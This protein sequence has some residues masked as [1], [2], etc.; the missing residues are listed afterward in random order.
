MTDDTFNVSKYNEKKS[1]LDLYCEQHKGASEQRST[2]W[3]NLTYV[4]FGGSE[5]ATLSGDS[6]YEKISDLVAKKS[7]LT[8]LKGNLPMRWGTYLEKSVAKIVTKVFSVDM[9]E[10]GALPG[11][12]K[13]SRCSP[14]GLGLM[15]ID[16]EWMI[17]LFEYKNPFTRVPTGHIPK[18]Y[19]A[20]LQTG[21]CT[22]PIADTALFMEFIT[23]MCNQENMGYNKYFNKRIHDKDGN[24]ES[25]I[26]L[27]NL[28]IYQTEE[29]EYKYSNESHNS[30]LDVILNERGSE[31]IL[32][33]GD[34]SKQ[35]IG[36]LFE[37]A[38]MNLISIYHTSPIIFPWNVYKKVPFSRQ[39]FET[40]PHKRDLDK[41]MDRLKLKLEK[42]YRKIKECE[43][44][45]LG[46]VGWKLFQ[47]G[48]MRFDNPDPDFMKKQEPVMIETMNIINEIKADPDNKWAIYHKYYPTKNKKKYDDKTRES[49]QDTNMSDFSFDL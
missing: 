21:L 1:Q 31:E 8:V 12:V 11:P 3:Y 46:I 25:P 15:K 47:W 10:L 23:R 32:D 4:T 42:G 33:F 43:A 30:S 48:I 27:G 28:I 22:I 20:Q 13:Y 16:G 19:I 34:M 29:Q 45:V 44:T 2:E 40:Q 6:P 39:T 37:L 9:R 14:D 17:V 5:Q 38:E 18:H 49:Y 7:G 26:A 41:Y 36:R 24:Y 35:E